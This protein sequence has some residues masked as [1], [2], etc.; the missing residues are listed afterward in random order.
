MAT[1]PEPNPHSPSPSAPGSL[2]AEVEHGDSGTDPRLEG[3]GQGSRG[4]G[5]G[6]EGLGEK[7][8]LRVK[9]E[10]E[11]QRGARR[12]EDQGPEVW[13]KTSAEIREE[14]EQRERT[15]GRG[16]RVG[17]CCLRL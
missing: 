17:L 10:S 1:S 8:K 11:N 15:G 7:V 5:A 9:A 6:Q 2:G 12:A 4:V 16:H 13:R 14:Q 3:E